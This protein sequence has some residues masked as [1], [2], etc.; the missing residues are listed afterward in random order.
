MKKQDAQKKLNKKWNDLF[1]EHSAV[2]RYLDC[3]MIDFTPFGD[4]AFHPGC[5][6]R[7]ELIERDWSLSDLMEESGLSRSQVFG[8]FCCRDDVDEAIARGLSRAFGTGSQ[9][10][11]NL[12]E[13]FHKHGGLR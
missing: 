11:L 3:V 6:I 2:N 13:A 1:D 12:Q 9:V 5:Y 8:V 10:W 4:I 7:D